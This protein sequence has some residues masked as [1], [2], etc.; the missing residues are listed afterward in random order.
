MGLNLKFEKM[1]SAVRR[2]NLGASAP[3]FLICFG[4]TDIVFNRH[5]LPRYIVYFPQNTL[6]FGGIYVNIYM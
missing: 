5:K 1:N 4:I 6:Q 2:E 3:R